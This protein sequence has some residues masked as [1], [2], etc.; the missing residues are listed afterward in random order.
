[1]PDALMRLRD[2]SRFYGDKL[3]FRGAS[4]ALRPGRLFLITGANGA[5][6][7][8][9]LRLMAGLAA[10]DAGQIERRESLKCAYLGHATFIYPDLTA[11]Q[12]LRFWAKAAGAAH[13]R[14]TLLCALRAME[15]EAYADERAGAF[16][17]GMAQ[18]LN[19]ARCLLAEP[20][21]L[22]LDEPFTGLDARSRELM[23]AKIAALR[24]RGACIAL[25]SHNPET[26]GEFADAILKIANRR[27]ALVSGQC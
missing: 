9:L 5:G 12:N 15:L 2:V 4:L 19:F 23:R 3:I 26:D 21:L 18:R 1:M 13:D 24:E 20:E 6:K 11:L 14:E 8:A 27:L 22:L 16:S 10:P 25:V 17:R 7:S